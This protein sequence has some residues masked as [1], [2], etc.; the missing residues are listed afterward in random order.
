MSKLL[1]QIVAV[2]V[3]MVVSL[4]VVRAPA[5]D[6]PSTPRGIAPPTRIPDVVAAQPAGERVDI[7]NVPRAVRRAVAADAARRF[8]VSENDVVLVNAERLTWSD[9][10]MG[11]PEPGQTYTQML[12]PGF[13]ITAKTAA[14]QMLYHTDSRGTAVTCAASHFQTGPKQLPAHPAATGAEPRTHPPQPATPDR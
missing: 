11:C 14:G 6:K 1:R 5:A 7:A 4:A 10:A 13:R 8:A 12:V 9:G 2:G 3:A